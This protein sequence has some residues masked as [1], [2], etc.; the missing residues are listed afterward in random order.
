MSE[1]G[2]S[3]SGE[4]DERVPVDMGDDP[5]SSTITR[6]DARTQLT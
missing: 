6:L 4:I 3:G 1:G 5:G 2:F